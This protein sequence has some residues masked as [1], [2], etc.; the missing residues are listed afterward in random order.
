MGSDLPRKREPSVVQTRCEVNREDVTR[1]CRPG[2]GLGDQGKRDPS[3]A[4]VGRDIRF[5]EGAM[6]G[7][8]QDDRRREM[9]DGAASDILCRL[10]GVSEEKGVVPARARAERNRMIFK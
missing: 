6:E 2:L 1:A 3:I 8:M 4:G 9:P 5:V 10:W 7:E